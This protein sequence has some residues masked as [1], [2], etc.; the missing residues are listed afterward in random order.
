MKVDE[1][2][3][4]YTLRTSARAKRIFLS[5]SARRGLE[6]VLPL[7]KNHPAKAIDTLLLEKRSWIEKHLCLLKT[8]TL[9]SKPLEK[10]YLLNLPAIQQIFFFS[11]ERNN[12]K[13]LKI[14]PSTSNNHFLITGPID[15]LPKVFA[16]LCKWLR[17]LAAKF[18]EPMLYPLSLEMGLQYQ[19]L[20]IRSQTTLWGSCNTRGRISLNS[21]LLFLPPSVLRYIMVHELCHL[22]HMNHSKRF[23]QLVS[24]WDPNYKSHKQALRQAKTQLPAWLE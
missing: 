11:Y 12:K 3:P 5:I 1:W 18:F 2:P 6:I 13:H 4:A 9:P 16:L 24:H 7:R 21:K 19:K 10:P 20:H 23:W 15:D 8:E 14:K 22:R 17:V